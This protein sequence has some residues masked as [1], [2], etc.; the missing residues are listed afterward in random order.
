M[1]NYHSCRLDCKERWLH[2]F[3]PEGP[4]AAGELECEHSS[5]RPFVERCPLPVC[6]AFDLPETRGSWVVAVCHLHLR[7]L[8]WLNVSCKWQTVCLRPLRFDPPS[9]EIRCASP[10]G[11]SNVDLSF[12]HL[13]WK[14]LPTSS[15]RRMGDVALYSQ[16]SDRTTL[17]HQ[18]FQQWSFVPE[19]H[20]AKMK[21]HKKWHRTRD[22]VGISER[23]KN[24]KRWLQGQH[25]SSR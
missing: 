2:W 11:F 23:R 13:T 18:E 10:E 9:A 7:R 5:T 8:W 17:Y 12:V 24:C 15:R 22:V 25:T 6:S 4:P 19:N 1:R 20:A 14:D 21:D 16:M 3:R